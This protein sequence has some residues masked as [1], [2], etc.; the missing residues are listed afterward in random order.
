MQASSRELKNMTHHLYYKLK[1]TSLRK[2]VAKSSEMWPIIC[3]INYNLF[4]QA[5]AKS[6]SPHDSC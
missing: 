4:T 6:S 5:V 3:I 1:L 2:Q